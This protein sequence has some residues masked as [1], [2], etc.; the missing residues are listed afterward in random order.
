MT[1][2][3]IEA[4]FSTAHGR[5][6]D[7]DKSYGRQCK[8]TIDDYGP[9]LFGVDW[10]KC[11]G[12]A[13][14]K[15][16]PYVAPAEYWNW[17]ANNPTR[18][19]QIPSRGDVIVWGGNN[20]NQFGHIAVVLSASQSGI[21]VLQQDG[22]AEPKVLQQNADGSS[23]YYSMRPIHEYDLAYDNQYTGPVT[24]WLT[25]KESKIL[26][27]TP[28]IINEEKPMAKTYKYETQ[29]T[30][31]NQVARSFYGNY[32]SKPTGITLHHWGNDGQKF[33]DVARF[34]ATNDVP[35]SAHYVVEDGRI[36]CLAAPEVAT[37]HAGHPV[38][39]GT[40]VGIELRPEMTSGDIDTL[41]QL[42]YE[43]ET[44][45]GSLNIYQHCDWFNTACAGRWGG[46]IPEIIDRV[47][48]MHKN[49]GRDPKLSS[50][51]DKKTE[52][53]QTEKKEEPKMAQTA[54]DVWGYKNSKVNGN[55]DA[56]AILTSIER[57][58]DEIEKKL[59]EK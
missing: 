27:Y 8:D 46:K 4:W 43:L 38:G 23:G 39:N 14:A 40:T 5:G 9:F 49:G 30:T 51:S 35:T 22:G 16:V 57:K 18:P 24:G 17:T 21:K 7:P 56:Y 31:K 59:E 2:P 11:V 58:L 41:V 55:R 54:L 6:T 32:G 34:L 1:H 15:D 10:R 50:G 28:P 19:D 53:V 42:I 52:P 33:D 20:N 47:N 26:A 12:G 25:P 37:F 45:Y 48:T 13:N 29:W 36:A 3:R 44:T